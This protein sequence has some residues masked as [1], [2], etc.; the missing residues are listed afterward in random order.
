MIQKS[1]ISFAVLSILVLVAGCLDY[2]TYNSQDESSN[3]IVNEIAEIEQ[4][5]G[6]GEAENGGGSSG[7]NNPETGDETSGNL[8]GQADSAE[9]IAVEEEVVLPDLQEEELLSEEAQVIT[10]KENEK[11]RLNIKVTDPDE[12]TVSYTFSKPLNAEG[13]WQTSY[14]D[15]GEY[16]V[17][18]TATDGRLTTEKNVKIIVE[19][20]NVPPIISPLRDI[21]VKEGETVTF[22]PTVSD[23]NKDPVTVRVSEPLKNAVFKTDHTSAGEYQILVQATD[24]ELASEESFKLTVTDVNVL[25]KISGLENLTINEGETVTLQPVIT[26]LDEDEIILTISEPA[27]DDGIWKTGFTDHGEYVITV[28]AFDGK[29]T[30][31]ERVKVVVEDVNMPPEI[32]EVT[33]TSN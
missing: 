31:T 6:L 21:I 4:E 26:D 3:N 24:G 12:D 25:P 20:V 14:G 10:V 23:P 7:E 33:L 9:A 32:V 5:L 27:G 15:A 22:E 29:D 8:T 18:I 28:K 19:R 2:K 1:V 13:T 16:I 17:T 11:V 30:V